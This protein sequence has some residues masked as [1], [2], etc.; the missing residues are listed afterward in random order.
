MSAVVQASAQ[1]LGVAI[2]SWP[3]ARSRF[4]TGELVRVFAQ[5]VTTMEHFYL[6][7]RPEEAARPDVAQLI[8]WIVAEFAMPEET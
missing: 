6:A 1:G 4:D 3:L 5:E 7:H 8:D 2:V